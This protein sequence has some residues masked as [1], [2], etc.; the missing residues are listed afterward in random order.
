[1]KHHSIGGKARWLGIPFIKIKENNTSRTCNKC[2]NC[3]KS[4]RKKQGL[5]KCLNCNYQVNADFNGC[6]NIMN[7]LLEYIS[8]NGAVAYA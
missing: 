6:L 4:N 1:M 7:R 3:D 2:G 5:F 8:N